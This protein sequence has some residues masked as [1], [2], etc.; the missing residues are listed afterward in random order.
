MIFCS[1]TGAVI[2]PVPNLSRLVMVMWVQA[3]G[4]RSSDKSGF[5]V[6]IVVLG[7]TKKTQHGSN[8][9]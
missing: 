9:I 2:H 8:D 6:D 3:R 4:G 5:K 1:M 7:E